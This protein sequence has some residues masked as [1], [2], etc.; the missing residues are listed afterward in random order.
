MVGALSII[1]QTEN[2]FSKMPYLHLKESVLF[3][4][5]PPSRKALRP[6]K[7]ANDTPQKTTDFHASFR[8]G[9]DGIGDGRFIWSKIS[10][11]GSNQR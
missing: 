9:K 6:G 2:A 5:A 7:T 11:V 10:P 8:S 1:T 3:G 4:V